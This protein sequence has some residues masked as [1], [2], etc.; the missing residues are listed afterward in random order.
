M[1][2][3]DAKSMLCIYGCSKW[4]FNMLEGSNAFWKMICVKEELANYSCISEEGSMSD[5]N[6]L[7]SNRSDCSTTSSRIREAMEELNDNESGLAS[8]LEYG[9]NRTE[10]SET[11]E[12]SEYTARGIS[13]SSLTSYPTGRTS[14]RRKISVNKKKAAVS[15]SLSQEIKMGFADKPMHGEFSNTVGNDSRVS[16]HKVYLRGLQMRKNIVQSNFE[17]WRIYANTQVPVTRL[18]PDLDFNAD[19]KQVSIF[20]SHLTCCA[21]IT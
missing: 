9:Y 8:S 20:R 14:K 13:G 3:L 15:T 5:N 1:Q 19:V 7:N 17:G 12:E 21:Y 10:G 11:E 18:T 16:W 6:A 4:S 2:F